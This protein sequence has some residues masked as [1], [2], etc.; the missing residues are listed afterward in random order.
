M[1]GTSLIKLPEK[2]SSKY[3]SFILEYIL[4]VLVSDRNWLNITAV[5]LALVE[6]DTLSY[7]R[8][9][10]VVEKDLGNPVLK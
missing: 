10:E 9:C 6:E 8:I 7:E 5:A 3:Q 2:I 1:G 4:Q